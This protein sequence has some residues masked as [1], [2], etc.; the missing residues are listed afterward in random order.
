MVTGKEEEAAMSTSTRQHR[1]HKRSGTYELKEMDAESIDNEG[2][3]LQRS[4]TFDLSTSNDATLP[5]DEQVSECDRSWPV[6][7]KRLFLM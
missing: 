6:D 5:I 7:L 3:K 2:R 1:T 4:S